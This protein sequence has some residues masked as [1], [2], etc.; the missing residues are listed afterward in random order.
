MGKMLSQEEI[1][2]A[3]GKIISEFEKVCPTPRSF[4]QMKRETHRVFDELFK[5]GKSN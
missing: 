5:Q 4:E 3:K 1:N 2:L